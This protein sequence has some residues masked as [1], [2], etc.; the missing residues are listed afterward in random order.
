MNTIQRST[1][2]ISST[3][4][5]DLGGLNKFPVYMGCVTH[6]ESEDI[7]A[8]MLWHISPQNG[9]IQ[10]KELIP[11]DILY[12]ENHA[13][14]I[15][16]I[17]MKHHNAFAKFIRQ[18][19]PNSILEIGAA[20]GILSKIYFDQFKNTDWTILEPN[21]I[22]VSGVKA[23]VIK[24]F[25]D[26]KFALGHQVDAF[27]HSH[28]FEHIYDPNIFLKHV[29]DFLDDGKFFIFSLPNMREML[30]RKYTNCI[31]FEHT[32]F[33]TEPYI[34]HLLSRHG[35]R[36]LKREYF[37]DDHSIFY[38]C[39]RDSNVAPC[40]LPTG[41]YE[42]NKK[43][44]LEYVDYHKRLIHDLNNKIAA[45]SS[46]HNIYLFGAHV[47]AQYLIGFGLDTS[48]VDCLL[49][50]DPN[51]QG[52]R[53]Y[54]TNLNVASPNILADI[55]DP[56]VILKAGVYNNEIKKDILDNINSKTIFLE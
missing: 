32:V 18:F 35:F 39:M 11:L 14:A 26:D 4:M 22:P 9:L 56:V 8:D 19:D 46:F 47:F 13:G 48:R 20:H 50:N 12:P 28:V 40:N 38:A 44:Y 33:L 37:L 29:S 55:S 52:K 49:D 24:G 1:D 16:S 45:L 51:K 41:L 17:W 21:P 6:P 27:I 10:L 5:E 30:Q 53:L 43:I 2:V 34:D 36:V 3:E 54:G 15:G 42:S 7:F 25:F 23:R 31:N